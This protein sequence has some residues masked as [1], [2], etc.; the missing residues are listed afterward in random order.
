MRGFELLRGEGIEGVQPAIIVVTLPPSSS[1]ILHRGGLTGTL[2]VSFVPKIKFYER[3]SGT[4][5]LQEDLLAVWY[6]SAP[7]NL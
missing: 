4:S 5:K 6:L 2:A 1:L 3:P 7:P